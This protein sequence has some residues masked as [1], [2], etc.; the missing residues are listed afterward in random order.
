MLDKSKESQGPLGEQPGQSAG[1]YG[2]SCQLP[3]A[4]Q[5]H[6]EGCRHTAQQ[7]PSNGE[8]VQRPLAQGEESS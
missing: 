8:E 2:K 7:S 3:K 5:G 1:G 4:E 6:Q